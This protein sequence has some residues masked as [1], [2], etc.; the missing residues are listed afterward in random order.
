M[1]IPAADALPTKL[2]AFPAGGTERVFY[3]RPRRLH[4]AHAEN[5]DREARGTCLNSEHSRDLLMRSDLVLVTGACMPD[6]V[7]ET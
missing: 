7:G 5:L 4:C 6:A 2:T 3:R 1:G